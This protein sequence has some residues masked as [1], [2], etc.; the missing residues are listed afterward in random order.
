MIA[1]K[2]TFFCAIAVLLGSFTVVSNT[3]AQEKETPIKIFGYF[4]NSFQH[5]TTFGERPRQNSFSLQQLNLFF[6]KD[7]GSDWTAFVNFE[8]LNNFSSGRQW[9]STKLEEAWVK[10]RANMRFNL[11]LGLLIPIFNNL[12]EIKNRTPLLPYIIRPLAYETSFGVVNSATDVSNRCL[13]RIEQELQDSQKVS[14]AQVLHVLKDNLRITREAGDRIAMLVK[15][16]RTF[17]RLD[18]AEYQKVDIHEGVD[19]SLTLIES[20]WRGRITIEKD[21]TPAG[22]LTCYASQL[23]QV[24][25]T[26]LKNAVNAIESKGTI[27]ITTK[28]EN[29]HMHI[30]IADTGRGMA[31]A[32]LNKIFDFGFSAGGTRVKMRS[33][34]SAAYNIVQKHRG[35]IRVESEEGKGTTFFIDLPIS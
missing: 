34:L 27:S 11:K 2:M 7:I 35:T 13:A 18:E 1:N 9:G 10:Y 6:Q 14:V 21:Y 33:G 25:A 22:E 28:R 16:L 20:E 31:P 4:Q 17:A 32:Q 5:W 19:S 15:S 12:N 3:F 24:F 23:N 8:F 29:G 26:L 30:E